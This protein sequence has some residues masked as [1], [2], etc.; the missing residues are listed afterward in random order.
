M[1]NRA[2][3]ESNLFTWLET[4]SVEFPSSSL[5][6]NSSPGPNKAQ[7]MVSKVFQKFV[8]ISWFC[9]LRSIFWCCPSLRTS[10]HLILALIFSL[11]MKMIPEPKANRTTMYMQLR[12]IT[13]MNTF[14]V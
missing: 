14:K 5:F 13:S 11:P 9:N 12:V 1:V 3:P 7:N 2:K 8:Q 4:R 6:L 10:G